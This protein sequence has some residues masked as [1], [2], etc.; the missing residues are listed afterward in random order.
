MCV[1]NWAINKI[2]VRYIFPIPRLDDLLNQVSGATLF[3]KLDLKCGYYQ[4][5]FRLGYKW[6][7]E[8]KMRM[9]G[10]LC[11]SDYPMH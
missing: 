5:H 4:I 9:S 1:D 10:W 3:T 2:T 11:H 8:F 6:K 7:T